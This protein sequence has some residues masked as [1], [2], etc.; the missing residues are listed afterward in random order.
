VGAIGRQV[1]HGGKLL[2]ALTLLTF[3]SVSHADVDPDPDPQPSPW[4][5]ADKAFHFGAS[6]GLSAGG[7]AFGVASFDSR[8]AAV[9]LG[10]GI[11]LGLGAAKEGLDAA[12]LGTPS[13]EDLVW[14]V[15]GTALGLG[16]A[17]TFDA[18]LRGP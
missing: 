2:L 11:A 8:W 1:R 9:A 4:F 7:Y 18:A 13:W 15:V 6:F 12:G 10:S 16:V 14:D 5:G 3:S 17:V